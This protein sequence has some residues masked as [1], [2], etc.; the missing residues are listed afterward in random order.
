MPLSK[1]RKLAEQNDVAGDDQ[2]QGRGVS[3][4]ASSQAQGRDQDVPETNQGIEEQ[5][6]KQ[7]Q[8]EE[9]GAAS[10][11]S[12]SDELAAKAKERQERFRALQARAV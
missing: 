5:E 8:Q 9:D 7:Q 11:R 2:K 4:D 10:P 3:T 1:K 6:E 12:V